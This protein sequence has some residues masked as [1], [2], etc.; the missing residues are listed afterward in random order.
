MVLRIA[1]L[2]SRLYQPDLDLFELDRA[3]GL[4]GVLDRGQPGMHIGRGTLG[5][6]HATLLVG[7]L[8]S[9]DRQQI[10]ERREPRGCNRRLP[11]CI[12]L[13]RNALGSASART[14]SAAQL[15]F[16]LVVVSTFQAVMRPCAR[17]E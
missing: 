15:S 14:V 9:Q 5:R 1:L 17:T 2:F 3:T 11:F 10:V 4:A 16:P 7:V 13:V 8:V 12:G 6:L